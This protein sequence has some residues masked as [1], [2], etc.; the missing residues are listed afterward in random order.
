MATGTIRD[1]IDEAIG[2]TEIEMQLEER[3]QRLGL[4]GGSEAPARS[5]ESTTSSSGTTGL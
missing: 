1:Q 3:R 2:T 5:D 4:S